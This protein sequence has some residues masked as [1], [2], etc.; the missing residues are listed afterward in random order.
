[1]ASTYTVT[2]GDC[3]ANIAK[4]FG[5][6]DYR[7]IY[8]HPKN[9]E[10]R[11]KRPNPNLIFP[12][13]RLYIPDRD[14]TT[15]TC[16]TGRSH[17]FRA[18]NAGVFLRVALKD[19]TGTPYANKQYTV[20]VGS[21]LRNGRTDGEGRVIEPIAPDTSEARL[22]LWLGENPSA[23]FFAWTLRLGNLD[24]AETI[25]GAQARLN[26]L[27]FPCG[28]VDG[29]IGPKT[30]GALRRFQKAA[31]LTQS[32]ALDAATIARLKSLHD[33]A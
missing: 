28:K 17:R 19:A 25:T 26:N 27:G 31:K 30:R 14:D 11:R 4:S 5:F 8:D 32:A 12:G 22:T 13:D 24:P 3:L 16:E 9:A 6:L 21:E 23:G 15:L 33:G 10:F 29:I 20:L 18:S 2:Q 7:R 1:M